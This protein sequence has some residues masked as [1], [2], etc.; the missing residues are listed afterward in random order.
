MKIALIGYG[1]MGKAIEQIALD[2]GHEIVFKVTSQ[3]ADYTPQQL[4]EA[5]VAI[6]FSIPDSALNNIYKCFEAQKPIVVGTTG[7]YDSYEKVA[8]D[9]A[10]QDGT[11]FHATNFSIGVNLFFEVNRKLAQLMDKH[12]DY[13]VSMTEIHH[14]QKLDEPSGTAISL[15]SQIIENVERK[16]SWKLG[17]DPMSVEIP[18]ESLREGQVPGTHSISY[19]N[20]IDKIT[21]EHEAKNRQG[22]AL[23][24]VLAAEYA[25]GKKG[26]LTMK[27]ML[28]A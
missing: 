1:K 7:W 2:R 16:H 12:K 4:N 8:H 6:E 28:S 24:A 19:E 9:C 10:R 13:E 5:D 21:I 27:D 26:I 25:A 15:A 17:N 3:N 14:T 20:S 11:L 18:I 22:F 23:G